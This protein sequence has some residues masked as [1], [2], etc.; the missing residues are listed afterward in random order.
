MPRW[1]KTPEDYDQAIIKSKEKIT[2]LQTQLEQEQAAL[3][4][5]EAGKR[6]AEMQ[7]IYDYMKNHDLSPTDVIN[8]LTVS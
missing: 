1:N 4:Q 2:R 3:V 5:L 7:V 8:Q 6:D